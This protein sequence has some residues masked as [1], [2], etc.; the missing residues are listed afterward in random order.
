MNKDISLNHV[1]TIRRLL[2]TMRASEKMH[3]LMIFG[4]AG[5][6]KSTTVDEALRLSGADACLGQRAGIAA[7]FL[8]CTCDIRKGCL[9][10]RGTAH[11]AFLKRA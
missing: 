4:S 2:N 5:W 7:P 8:V 10:S 1:E 3:A 9:R 11:R 6:G